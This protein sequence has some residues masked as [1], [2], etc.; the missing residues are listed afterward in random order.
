LAGGKFEKV[1]ASPS[2][3]FKN[4]DF[5]KPATCF[6]HQKNTRRHNLSPQRDDDEE[7]EEKGPLVRPLVRLGADHS[8]DFR[9]PLSIYRGIPRL[10]EIHA[11]G[12]PKL[13]RILIIMCSFKVAES[14][15]LRKK[16]CFLFRSPLSIGGWIPRLFE[17]HAR[18][19]KLT[20][21]LIII[22]IALELIPFISCFR[23]S[24]AT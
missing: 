8:E 23:V 9:S 3:Q 4:V 5:H 22:Y 19:P 12:P 7:E 14:Q 13:T 6:S 15:T 2:I 20:R 24:D 10:F 18:G 17:I 16:S 11:R 1:A 21:I